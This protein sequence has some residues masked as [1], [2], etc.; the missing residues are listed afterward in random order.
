[1]TT[2]FLEGDSVTDNF[3]GLEGEGSFSVS[4]TDTGF[5]GFTINLLAFRETTSV[6]I[7]AAGRGIGYDAINQLVE[8]PNDLTTVTI[9][10]LEPFFLGSSSANS[11][12]GDG[13]VTDIDAMATSPTKIHSSLTLIDASATTGGVTISAGATNTSG[14]G[15]FDD[16]DPPFPNITI[17][18][19]GLT[20]KG[21]SGDD[22]I[23]ND[24][25]NGTVTDGNGAELCRPG[26]S[27]CK[28]HARHRF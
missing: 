3:V 19:T 25:K 9:K 23:E 14:A 4:L 21:G 22:S 15:D 17:T 18:Y 26:R 16:G 6:T 7:Q 27:R 2:L 13:V 20:I 12:A 1:M 10:G 5:G 8:L 28:G 11:N 24:A